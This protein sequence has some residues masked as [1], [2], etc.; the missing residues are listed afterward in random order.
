MP[1]IHIYCL[2]FCLLLFN[3]CVEP[4]NLDDF[5]YKLVVEGWIKEGE[6]PHVILTQNKPL[7]SN[8][9]STSIE[10]MVVRW[11]KVSVSDGEETEVLSGRIDKN[12]FPP[13]IYRGSRLSGEAG[14]TYTLKVEY[15]GREWTAETTIPASIPLT[16]LVPEIAVNDTLYS[17]EA[18][19]ND[20]VHEKNY[21]KFF[22]K[23]VHKNTRFLSSLLGNFD[24]NL[25]NGQS[26][27]VTVNQGINQWQFKNFES[28]FHIRDTVLVQFCTLPEFGFRYWTAYENELVNGQ[29]PFFPANQNLPT[30]ISNGGIGIW[31]GY[32]QKT[33]SVS[34][35]VQKKCIP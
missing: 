2:L 22:T 27:T 13:F 6:V 31:C 25:F 23:V 16:S 15:S 11:A 34:Y 33:Y 17:I 20:P 35:P 32:G 19:F 5:E 29:N 8:I 26:M 28:H 9:D 7:L 30:N 24:D 4:S 21:Y 14:K 12:Y 1:K 10:D 3:G 18:T